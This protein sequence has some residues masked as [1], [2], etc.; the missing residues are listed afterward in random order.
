M[1]HKL[2]I[3]QIDGAGL[4]GQPFADNLVVQ[5]PAGKSFGKYTNG[6]TI[7]AAGLT[8]NEVIELAIREALNPTL[9]FTSPTTVDFNDTSVNVV[10]T[11]S[12]TILSGGATLANAVIQRRRNGNGP[13]VPILNGSIGNNSGTI[14]D[15]FTD[16]SFNLQS[17][18]Y[19][20]VVTDTAGG[21]STAT[22]TKQ[23]VYIPPT[24][25]LNVA[26]TTAGA[27]ES[28]L[29]REK[30]N[31][32]STISGTVTRNS[33]EVNLTSYVVQY[34]V[35]GAGGWTDI[36]SPVSTGASSASFSFTHNNAA[37]NGSDSISYRV[38][39][40]DTY[41]TYLSS[42]LT[43]SVVTVNFYNLIF[44]GPTTSVPTNSAAVRALGSKMLT[45]GA[46]PFN[47]ET[48]TTQRIFTVAVP[49]SKSIT[50]VLDLDALNLNITANY[51]LNTF[52]VNNYAGTAE[53]YKVYT[54]TNATPYSNG[55]TPPGNHRHQITRN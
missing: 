32:S 9:T 38:N 50:Q 37:L 44:Y 14:T 13:W 51:I 31:I 41:Q 39:V 48:G 43:S 27:Y 26:A 47:L 42:F 40:I 18:D 1:S 23:P 29:A 8:A 25:T 2:K 49:N 19:R 17:I 20:Y 7:P 3:K 11:Y 52:A 45:T 30:G 16:T 46:N 35:N 55:G 34:Q 4:G 33:P 54:M 36:G 15:S 53:T 24:I 21:T 10:L 6:Q 28:A 22:L 5:L 12:S